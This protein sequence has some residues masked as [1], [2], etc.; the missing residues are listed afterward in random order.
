MTTWSEGYAAESDYVAHYTTELNPLRAG[1]LLLDAGYAVQGPPRTACELG[2]GLGLSTV[3]HAAA[4]TATWWGTDFSPSQTLFARELAAAAG[5][6]LNL[7]DQSFAEFCARDDLPEFDFIALHGVWSW[8]SE[9]NRGLIVDFLRR[10]LR[11]G[12]TFYISYNA[13]PGWAQIIPVRN[14]MRSFVER[15]LPAGQDAERQA[16]AALDFAVRLMAQNPHMATAYPL[17]ASTVDGMRKNDPRY[18]A[19]EYLNRDWAPMSFADVAARLDAA[20]LGFAC[21]AAPSDHFDRYFLTTEQQQTLAETADPVLREGVRDF[22]T[23]RRFR[24]DYWIKGGRRTGEA[25]RRAA[26]G[27][28]RV[29]LARPAA[30]AVRTVAEAPA[31]S[32]LPAHVVDPLV[33]ALSDHRAREIRELGL[34][35]GDAVPDPADLG[36]V[37]LCLVGNGTLAFAQDDA[38]IEAAR[39]RAQALNREI[40]RRA[41]HSAE[42]SLLASPVTGGG[43]AVPR[44]QLQML[45]ARAAGAADPADWARAVWAPYRALGQV[46]IRDG[47]TLTSEAEN[48]AY[49]TEIATAFAATEL[50]MLK[51]LHAI[52]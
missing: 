52:D 18:V 26:F 10:K 22:M 5:I 23:N 1:P 43:L 32:E 27:G 29:V 36:R 50:P 35:L 31:A 11:V 6:D 14:L 15:A 13:L 25:V 3:V 48:L 24:K 44:F 46:L 30:Q 2:F 17:A 49:L 12:G 39:A 19:H 34:I 41:E 8:I 51:A 45:G 20:K 16:A 37:V 42:I 4:G 40:F 7:H 47:V 9:S 38:A 33:S 28:Q 21:S